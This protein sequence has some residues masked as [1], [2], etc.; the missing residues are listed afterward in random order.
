MQILENY[1]VFLPFLFNRDRK[2]I[3]LNTQ[4]G[5]ITS[6]AFMPQKLFKIPST[7]QGTSPSF[8]WARNI[9]I[10]WTLCAW[11]N[12]APSLVQQELC[13][14][15]KR[16]F[17]PLVIWKTTK[18]NKIKTR[19]MASVSTFIHQRKHDFILRVLQS[20]NIVNCLSD[21]SGPIRF[22]SPSSRLRPM[23]S[24]YTL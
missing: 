17:A 4:H 16:W 22:D 19:I 1:H 13:D 2:N 20:C 15:C 18:F 24:H 6:V 11:D 10:P 3:W 8:S 23:A 9:I 14:I 5:P 21:S 7:V 12:L